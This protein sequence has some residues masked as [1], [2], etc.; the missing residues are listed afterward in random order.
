MEQCAADCPSLWLDDDYCDDGLEL[1]GQAN[2]NLNIKSSLRPAV[3]ANST[4]CNV[5]KCLYDDGDCIVPSE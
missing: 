1:Y 2:K 5:E 3:L 4:S